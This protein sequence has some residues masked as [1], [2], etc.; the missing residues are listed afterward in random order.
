VFDQ[1]F[2]QPRALARHRSGPL[3]EERLRYLGHLAALGLSRRSLQATAHYTLFV[4]DHLCLA[5]RPSQPIPLAEVE[6][7]A[8][9]WADKPPL[10][11]QRCPS[12]AS[13]LQ[14]AT[15]WLRF[16]GRLQLPPASP[17]LH[18]E[19]VDAFADYLR[20]ERGLS[21]RTVDTYCPA[22][23]AF[24]GDLCAPGHP[25]A[26]LTTT[27]IDQ[28]LIAR[29]SRGGYARRT[30]AGLA[31]ALRCFFHFAHR[32]GWCKAGL[33]ESIKGPR[34]FAQESLPTGPSWADV[35]RLLASTEEGGLIDVRDRAI[36]M[37]LAVYGLRA[38]EVARLRLEDFDWEREQLR[39]MRPKTQSSQVYPLSRR[40]GDAVLD[41]LKQVRPRCVLREVFLCSRAPIRPLGRAALWPIVAERLRRLG[42]TCPHRGPHAIRHA[43]ATHLLA[44]GLSLKEIGDHL[45][46]QRPDTT[47]LYAKVDLTGLQRV[48]EFDMGGLL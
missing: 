4:A 10:F 9:L 30:V 15:A 3:L 11:G 25:L 29:V 40:V 34:L 17:R 23:E 21:P 44:Q 48:A 31:R 47:R 5:D 1:L 24:L 35:Q 28:A 7:H 22:V 38:G 45:G 33:A 13:F 46:H 20:R 39:L 36:L 43:C 27:Q 26:S 37:L 16:L 42:V 18:A 6:R 8:L 32:R 12:R 14:H 2:K 41:Y 19:Q